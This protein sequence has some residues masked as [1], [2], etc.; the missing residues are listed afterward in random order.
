MYLALSV[1]LLRV[2]HDSTDLCGRLVRIQTLLTFEQ[3]A[4]G[5][6]SL[7]CAV[8]TGDCTCETTTAHAHVGTVVGHHRFVVLLLLQVVSGRPVGTS[9][10]ES[11]LTGGSAHH[12]NL[13]AIY[14]RYGRSGN[15]NYSVTV[16]EHSVRR[17]LMLSLL[18]HAILVRIVL[19]RL[20]LEPL[21]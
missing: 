15:T 2:R 19:T 12:L 10:G 13:V 17:L 14:R 20:Q 9:A 7:G 5:G 1:S 4:C 16:R 8:G 3:A 21:L 6:L 11:R 18:L